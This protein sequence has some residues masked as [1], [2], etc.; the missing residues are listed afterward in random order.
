LRFFLVS[1][2]LDLLEPLSQELGPLERPL[3]QELIENLD[4]VANAALVWML[5]NRLQGIDVT[6]HLTIDLHPRFEGLDDPALSDRISELSERRLSLRTRA[7]CESFTSLRE[8]LI[9]LWQS[10]PLEEAVEGSFVAFGATV[11]ACTSFAFLVGV[12]SVDMG[13]FVFFSIDISPGASISVSI[14]RSRHGAGL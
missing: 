5:Q 3:R 12:A 14:I 9:T 6:W 8:L 2:S 11:S 1:K 7:L 4:G 10:S 13:A